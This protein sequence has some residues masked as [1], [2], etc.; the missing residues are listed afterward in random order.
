[1]RE[2]TEGSVK[3]IRAFLQKETFA[4][5]GPGESKFNGNRPWLNAASSPFTVSPATDALDG[6]R[7]SVR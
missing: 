5:K 6:C 2:P 3:I 4:R 1:V 7:F